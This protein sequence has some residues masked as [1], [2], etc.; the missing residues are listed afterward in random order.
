M[1][2]S[3]QQ[4]QALLAVSKWLKDP[5][6][7]QVFK[8]F[9]YAGT[10]KTTIAKLFA[11]NVHGTVLFGAFTGKATYV[12]RSKGC[13][14]AATIHSMIYLVKPKSKDNLKQLQKKFDD[15]VAFLMSKGYSDSEIKNDRAFKLL[16]QELNRSLKDMDQPLWVLNPDSPVEGAALVVLDE[17][18]MINEKMGRD[19]ESYKTKIL[20]LGDPAQLPP[21]MG[22]GYFMGEP[23]FMLTE[24]HRQAKDNPILHLATIVREGGYLKLG[25]YG[26]SS[27]VSKIDRDDAMGV[28]QILVGRNKTRFSHNAR[29]RQL[30]GFGD[31]LPMVGDRVV[32]L[33]NNSEAG[34][35]NGSQWKVKACNEATKSAI[36]M[37]ISPEISGMGA[38]TSLM[39][40]KCWFEGHKPGIWER[41]DYEEFDYGYALT[42]HKSQGSQWGSVLLQDESRCFRKDSRKWLYTGLTRAAEKVKVLV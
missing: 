12:L 38:A 5:N 26:E 2:L 23:D 17:V 11:E 24:I 1:S 21:V 19:I 8:L 20:V 4:D 22:T 42:V 13:P 25:Q 29:I 16:Q 31:V 39:A 18:S 3:K 34:I 10:G 36:S 7:K 14:N 15:H 27:V 37:D 33:R 9:G 41:K 30:L 32:C 40:H 28:D 6:G 35:L